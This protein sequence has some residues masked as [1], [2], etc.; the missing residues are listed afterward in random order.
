MFLLGAR[1]FHG[2]IRASSGPFFACSHTLGGIVI[3]DITLCFPSLI[4]WHF[5]KRHIIF[6]FSLKILQSRDG[7]FGDYALGG[8]L[9]PRVYVLYHASHIPK[10]LWTCAKYFIGFFNFYISNKIIDKVYFN[11]KVSKGHKIEPREPIWSC[12]CSFL[13]PDPPLNP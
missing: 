8:L 6:K 3:N 9:K 12:G 1:K 4:I 11:C 13:D 7:E 2:F 10:V 5:F